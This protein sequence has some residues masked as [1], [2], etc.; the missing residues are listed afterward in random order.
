MDKSITVCV[1]SLNRAE[2]TIQCL[3]SVKMQKGLTANI[4]VID[5]GSEKT[6]IAKLR[7]YVSTNDN[8]QLIEIGR[9]IGVPG[10]RNKAGLLAKDKYFVAI[11]NDAEFTDST[12][13]LK[14]YEKFEQEAALDVIGFKI[15][16]H[17]DRKLD[18]STWPYPKRQLAHHDREFKTTR[19]VGCGHAIRTSKFKE[20]KGYDENLFFYWEE[21]DLSIRI[22]NSGGQII[23]YPAIVIAHKISPDSRVNWSGKRFYFYTRNALLLNEKYRMGAPRLFSRFFGYL[24]KAVLNGHTDQYKSAVCDFL[25]SRRSYVNR[26]ETLSKRS[27]KYIKENESR[28]RGSI[29]DRMNLELFSRMK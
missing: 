17:H 14:I 28:H 2:E 15:I 9:N 8:I 11:D 23:Y 27:L 10:G 4:I 1:L 26:G 13:L 12:S 6:E 29:I 16:R 20:L 21:L 3:K 22:I 24:V 18:I 5:Q 7:D 25:K 19:F